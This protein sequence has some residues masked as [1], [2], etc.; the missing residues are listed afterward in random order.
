MSGSVHVIG[1]GLAGLSA[2]VALARR[3][4]RLVLSEAARQAG[5][6]CR[7]YHDERLGM[8]IDNGNHLVLS[9]NGAVERYVEA[10]GARSSL[11]GPDRAEFP[12]LDLARGRRWT[13]RPSEGR[14]PWWLLDA[15][16]RVPDT[17]LGD[18]LSL[19]VLMR[20]HPGRRLDEVIRC[21]GVLWE[22]FLRPLFVSA[23]NTAP[24][25]A[26]ADLA[27]AVV[28]ET[29]GRGGR[30]TRPLLATPTLA[31]AF[32]DPALG[33]LARHGAGIR[34]GRTLRGIGLEAG[35]VRSLAFDDGEETLGPDDRVILAVPPWVAPKL[36]P[37][38]VAPDSFRAIV[39]AHYRR[40]APPGAP[41]M[42]GLVGATA[43]WVFAFGDRL[44][45][46]VSAA[47]HLVDRDAEELAPLL[48]RDV[49]AALDLPPEEPP[50][51]R[52]VKEK[53]ATFA[54]TPDQEVRRPAAR[55]AWANL[56]LAGD[57]TATGLPATIE[58]ALRS[59]EAAAAQ[60]LAPPLARA[61]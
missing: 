46:T 33:L 38:L 59:G 16:R 35:R 22:S 6:R 45:V 27:G 1:A 19:A 61:A 14:L 48:W 9:G 43:D 41:A 7:S 60:V 32:V 21:E 31:A 13:L 55:T 20:R 28:R 47:D 54:P 34:F 37:G 53:R 24:E 17:R 8:A 58:G 36:L 40:S 3:G 15:R 51:W 5:G 49:T 12:F 11:T 57:W 23:L 25:E 29:L 18:Y 42:I 52:I 2:S 10:I 56:F 39:N 44:S 26:A 50:A 30:Y 4:V